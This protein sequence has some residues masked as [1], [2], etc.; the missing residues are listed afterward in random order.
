MKMKKIF[1]LILLFTGLTITSCDDTLDVNTD[2]N[3][4]ATSTP[5]LTLPVAE[6]SIATVL[7]SDYNILGS[8]LAHYWTTGPTAAQYDFIDKYNIRTTD[9]DNSW[10]FVYTSVLSD[11]EFVRRYGIENE[12]P[13]YTAIAQ[14]LQ[15]YMYQIMVDLYDKIPYTDALKGKEG[16]V[17]PTFDNGDQVYDN[18]IVKI[19]E[20]LALIDTSP[21]AI[22]PANDDLIYG[23]NMESWQKFG[24]TLK[25]KI[26]IRQALARPEV[27]QAGIE[28]L[29]DQGATF[30]GAGDDA[31]INFSTS[32]HNENPFWQ[33][34]NQTTF[35]NLV[36]S[37]TFLDEIVD[38]GD[39]RLEALYDPSD[40]EGQYVGLD[41]GVGTQDGGLFDDYAHPSQT[42]I[43]SRAAPAYLMTGYESLFLQAE[44]AQRGW[45][46]A[47][48]KALYDA[49]VTASFTMWGKSTAGFL[50]DGE[51]YEYDGQ[52]ETIY[53]QKWL[54]FNG[55]QGLEG[56][57][58][59]RR[60][61]VPALPVS[62]QGRPLP[63]TFPLRLIWP[64]T[65]RSA[66]PNV[67]T[68]T[69]VDTPV[70]WDVTF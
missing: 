58:E 62:V 50:G 16:N 42:F 67:P 32:V 5:Q 6:V 8:M 51:V 29:Y 43:I 63:N 69:T 52:I 22:R 23:G 57:M 35:E 25:L 48:D 54:S 65:E 45:S 2:P 47:D 28:A 21:N 59:W 12:Q 66:N 24:N 18:L 20:A 9:Y 7:E 37:T 10:I 1:F 64:N 61:G 13:N 4:P 3:N 33:E 19:D 46:G 53:Y 40:A 56:W 70:W 27:A 11:L 17:T 44:A 14:L 30:I 34:L 26:F 60:T 49:A 36:A 68:L 31:R 41:Q 38:T 39:P 55:E 15:A